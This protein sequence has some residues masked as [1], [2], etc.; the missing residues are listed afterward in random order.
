MRTKSSGEG[1]RGSSRPRSASVPTDAA[2][3]EIAIAWA[4]GNAARLAAQL[5]LK[6]NTPNEWRHRLRRG[7]RLSQDKRARLRALLDGPGK[8]AAWI[9]GLE[10]QPT[11]VLAA[12]AQRL[13]RAL[14]ARRD[15]RRAP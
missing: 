11:P 3:L 12:A 2:L 4:G 1:R 8:A 5:G 13:A 10:A 7:G 9:A 6:A 15:G 14:A